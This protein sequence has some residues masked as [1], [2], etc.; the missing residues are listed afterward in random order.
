MPA[1]IRSRVL[2]LTRATPPAETGLTHWS[3][4][5]LAK[6]VTRTTGVSISWHFVAKLWRENHLQ[7]WRQGTFKL[8]R[9][10]E[11]ADN[12][13]DIVGPYL[14]ADGRGGAQLRREDA[15]PSTGPYP[16]VAADHVRRHREAYPRLRPPRHHQPL[17]DNRSRNR[18]GL[19]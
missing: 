8:S 6:Y 11:F 2:A 13:M 18:Q 4:R 14:P 1:N 3:S 10:P 19:R 17:R 9:D 16:A 15:G 12:V 7:P 5:E